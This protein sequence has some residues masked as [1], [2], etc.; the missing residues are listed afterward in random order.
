MIAGR[1]SYFWPYIVWYAKHLK[2][3]GVGRPIFLDIFRY[4]RVGTY[5]YRFQPLDFMVPVVAVLLLTTA[6]AGVFTIIDWCLFNYKGMLDFKGLVR[7]PVMV[8]Y[9][10]PFNTHLSKNIPETS[11]AMLK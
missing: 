4:V 2:H 10:R 3:P 9:T 6:I 11:L 7:F 5:K 1:D 8:A